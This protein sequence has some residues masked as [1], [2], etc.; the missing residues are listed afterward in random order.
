MVL[1]IVGAGISG[2]VAAL[3]AKQSSLDVLLV[4]KQTSSLNPSYAHFFNAHSLDI[5][6]QVGISITDLLAEAVAMP[7]AVTM[8]Y[9]YDFK[10]IYGSS[11]LLEDADYVQRSRQMGPYGA[12]LN[13]L[14]TVLQKQLL[15]K[16][17]A[18][19]ITCLW[20]H[21][22]VELDRHTKRVGLLDIKKGVK[23]WYKVDALLGCDG[24]NSSIRGYLGIKLYDKRYWQSFLSV[25]VV[26]DL[27][28]V[29]TTE[30]L[31]YW[32]YNPKCRCCVV[33]HDLGKHQVLQIPIYPKHEGLSS[34][35]NER[36]ISILRHLSLDDGLQCVI[37][38]RLVWHM[39]TYTV[40]SMQTDWIYLAGDAAHA[41]TPAGGLGLNTAIADVYN[42]V[43]KLGCRLKTSMHF[44]DNYHNERHLVALK[45]VTASI[46][47]YQDFMALPNS[48][49]LSIDYG[50]L[51]P[52]WMNAVDSYMPSL[53]QPYLERAAGSPFDMMYTATFKSPF[54]SWFYQKVQDAI[55][56]NSKHFSGLDQH[57]N[58]TYRE[59]VLVRLDKALFDY[60]K[61]GCR[62]RDLYYKCLDSGLTGRLLDYADYAYWTLLV[63]H[64]VSV[65]AV[66]PQDS[67]LKILDTRSMRL[68]WHLSD[69]SMI[70]FPG[71]LLVLI[72]PDKV[73][74]WQGDSLEDLVSFWGNLF[75]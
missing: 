45:N 30:A 21:K 43:W 48:Y 69:D 44:A 4:E 8:A 52:R 6:S 60:I 5:L 26:S 50:S 63:G 68:L 24:V 3:L 61:P 70:D 46:A 13:V 2:M 53:F 39:H 73:V 14:V 55:K 19:D 41:M 17:Q 58:D 7:Q 18:S 67:A 16:I 29:V 9:G 12:S 23:S 25:D 47:N 66:F 11:C 40:A 38:K 74:A 56:S 65:T 72:R 32:L 33:A 31:L 15:K 36:L 10:H 64:T 75:L 1:C 42:I 37:K 54:S 34:Y 49:G 51:V 62:V 28:E 71:G 57:M 20:E 35:P 27:R 22:F 59:S